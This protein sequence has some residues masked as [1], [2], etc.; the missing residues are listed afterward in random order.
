MKGEQVYRYKW[1]P[2]KR[3][4]ED[5]GQIGSWAV[6]PGDQG[7]VS[8]RLASLHICTVGMSAA[9]GITPPPS[10]ASRSSCSWPS[11][12]NQLRGASASCRHFHSNSQH[13]GASSRRTRR[14]SRPAVHSSG[15]NVERC[16]IG[17][18]RLTHNCHCSVSRSCRSGRRSILSGLP[19]GHPQIHHYALNS[20]TARSRDLA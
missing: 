2:M 7:S 16:G 15:L 3:P 4:V 9:V 6:V 10:N 13:A 5:Q 20:D 18:F 14:P 17:C 12:T 19:S 8:T 11:G 1:R